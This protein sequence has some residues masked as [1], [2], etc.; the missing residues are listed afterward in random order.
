M[1]AARIFSR[2]QLRSMER[3]TETRNGARNL[4]QIFARDG[5]DATQGPFRH[6][7]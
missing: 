3:A 1:E 5:H 6:A 4:S 2:P 7:V